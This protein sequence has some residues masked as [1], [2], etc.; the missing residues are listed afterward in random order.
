MFKIVKLG[1]Y[2]M[3][4]DYLDISE[5]TH[6]HSTRNRT[7]FIPPFPRVDNVRLNY[8]Y[9]FPVIWNE[10]PNAIKDSNSLSIFKRDLKNYFLIQY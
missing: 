4:R 9:T 7:N 6:E 5:Y 10:I 8:K 1:L 2:T 3:L